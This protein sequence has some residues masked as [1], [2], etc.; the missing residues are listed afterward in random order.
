MIVRMH[1]TQLWTIELEPGIELLSSF[2]IE[3]MLGN[4]IAIFSFDRDDEVRISAISWCRVAECLTPDL[5]F[6]VFEVEC[7]NQELGSGKPGICSTSQ[8]QSA[9][10]S[11]SFVNNNISWARVS[12]GK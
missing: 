11:A 6:M 5:F 9:K 8:Q 3:C 10:D 4:H 1:V 12:S 7:I 2:C